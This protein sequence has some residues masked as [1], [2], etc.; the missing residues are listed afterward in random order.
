[1]KN[2]TAEE[3]RQAFAR[4]GSA[5]VIGHVR[6]DGDCISSILALRGYLKCR[7][8][9]EADVFA[10]EYDRSLDILAGSENLSGEAPEKAYDTVFVVDCSNAERAGAGAE[11]MKTAGKVVNIDHH[12]SNTWYGNLNYVVPDAGSASEVLYG[13]F[14]EKFINRDI[15]Q[16]L[17]TG[18][19]HDTGVFQY[20][21]VKPETLRIAA[22]LIS[23]GFPFY[24]IIEKTFY[25]KSF[26][27]QKALGFVL[28][29][30]RLERDGEVVWSYITLKEQE[31]I[32]VT[33]VGLE[34]IVSVMRNTRGAEVSVFIYETEP[35]E[36]KVSTRSKNWMDLSDLCAK[37]GGGGHVR[38]AGCSFSGEEPEEIIKKLLEAMPQREEKEE[39]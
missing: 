30:A 33:P 4:C 14:E 24:E 12:I 35:G 13:L 3:I 18:M 36:F 9:I 15:A 39:V 28:S 32:G 23:Y 21:N 10:G 27:E 7:Y 22:K 31:E 34:G 8:G 2:N 5:A 38:A 16:C 1:M 37:F 19:A 29:R 25:E 26:P 20:S 17:Y 6:P 11:L